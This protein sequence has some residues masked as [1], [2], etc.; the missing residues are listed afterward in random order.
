MVSRTPLSEDENG[1]LKLNLVY[2]SNEFPS[3]DLSSLFTRLRESSKRHDHPVLSRF[4]DAA[5]QTL[6]QEIGR[7]HTEL[8]HL[9]PA[10]ESVTTLA[11]ELELRKG[12]LCGSID[13]VL[14][15]VLQLATYIGYCEN[16]P[17]PHT[18]GS[19]T[20]LLA[21]LGIGLLVSTAVSVSTSLDDL[22]T[23]GVEVL[24]IAFRLGLHVR[25]VSL[26]LEAP[27]GESSDSWAWCIYGLTANDA[28]EELDRIQERDA[29]PAA[30]RVF[31]SALNDTSVTVSGPPSRLKALFRTSGFFRDRKF[32]QLPV[33]GGLCHAPHIY[34]HDDVDIVVQALSLPSRFQPIVPVMSTNTGQ[35]FAAS[36]ASNLIHQV[37]FEIMTKQI[38]WD[39]VV[40]GVTERVGKAEIRHASMKA[41][42]VSLPIQQLSDALTAAIP[43]VTTNIDDL[44]SWT[45][46]S[47][48][49]QP[50][51]PR[52]S[53]QSKIAI[54]GMSCRMPGG[55]TDTQKFWELLEGGIDVHR[56]IPADRFDVESH[57]DV[58]GKKMNTSH[59]AYGCFI[60]EPGL[61]DAPFFNMSPREAEQTDPMQRLALVTAY[62]ALERSGYLANRT[63]A[64]NLARIGTWYGQASDDY[65]EVNTAQE[66]STYFI[67]GGCRAFG[68]GR[69]NYFF[70]FSGPSFNCDT[71]CS[72]SLATIQAACT[73][74]WAGDVDTVVAG[75]LNVLTNSDAFAGLC[76]G[77]FLTKTPNACKTWDCQADGYCRADGIGSIVLKRLD[78]AEADNDN[79]LGVITAAATNH[80]ANAVS[81]THPHAGHQADLYRQVM[82]R[83]CVNPLDVS[84][85]E[86]HGTGTQAGDAEEMQSITEVFAPIKGKRR[87]AKQAL[88]IGAVKANVG[89]GE[90][91]AGVTAL[92]KVLLMLQKSTIPPHIGIK[93]DINPGFPQDMEKRNLHI[94]FKPTDW[95]RTPD[96]KRIAVINNF[97]AA[98]GNTTVAL[99][100]P[101]LR[102]KIGTDPRPSHVFTV[103]AKSKRSLKG[104]VERLLNFLDGHPDVCLADLAYSL[105]ARRYHHNHRLAIH[106]AEVGSLKQQLISHLQETETQKHVSGPDAPPVAFVFTGQGAAE[107]SMNLQLYHHSPFFHAQITHLNL[108]AQGHRFPSFI[109][110]IDGSFPRDH[111]FSPVITQVAH[112]CVQIALAK[113]WETLGVKPELVMGHSLGEY[114]AFCVAGILSASDAIFLVGSR[115]RMLESLCTAGSHCMLAIKASLSAIED[116]VNGLSYDLACVNAP[117]ETVL[118]GTTAQMDEISSLLRDLGFRCFILDVPFAFHSAQMDPILNELEELLRKAV[119]FRAPTLPIVSA[120]LSKV[121]FDE[122]SVNAEY[123]RRATRETVNFLAAIQNAKTTSS[124]DKD[125]VWVEIG[126]HPVC[127]AFIKAIMEPAPVTVGSFCRGED[128]WTTLSQALGQLH[129]A[130]LQIRWGEFHQPFEGSLRLLD[131]PTYCW[132]EKRH[133]IQ[134]KG[135]WALTKGNT[136]YDSRG[137]SSGTST[138]VSSLRTATVQN[139]LE[140]TFTG[141]H[142]KVVMQ[143]DLMQSSFLAAAHGH[144]MNG[145]GVV[146][147]SIHADIAYTLSEYLYRQLV[148]KVETIHVDITHLEVT[149][150]LVAQKN[151]K[152]PQMIR[153]T[154]STVD[155]S[156]VGADLIWQNVSNDGGVSEPFA[157]C[158]ILYGNASHWLSSWASLT[159]L[160]Q[161]R[162]DALGKLAEEG[163]ASRFSHNMAYTLFAHNLVDYADNY[164]GM[165]IVVLNGFEAY[166]D[167]TLK[168]VHGHGDYTVPPYFID[169]VA[170][171]AG[172]IMNVSDASNSAETFC[173]TPGWK[174]MRFA[175]PL[176][177][178]QS[179][180]SYVKMIP[181]TEDPSVHFGD[182]YVLQK[183]EII[184]MVG[185][186][187]FRR[188]PRILL[189][190]FFS[191]PDSAVAKSHAAGNAPNP[192]KVIH[193][194]PSPPKPA[195][196]AQLPQPTEV[197]PTSVEAKVLPEKSSA[198]P[199]PATDDQDSTAHKALVLIAKEAG[200]N[201]AELTDDAEFA[202]LGVDSL[203]SLV[204][205]EKFREELGVNVAGSLFL[206]YP[207][208]GVLKAWLLEYY[209]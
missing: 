195:Q 119:L 133:W 192:P 64:T 150:G 170:H 62:E 209:S 178:G 96:R 179:Y 55:A 51:Q 26:N 169:S 152:T 206:E 180:R 71:A 161:G 72:S 191:A 86:F 165:Q 185:G 49:Q 15:C 196:S 78:D 106:A 121:V 113:Y 2:F 73:A 100:E 117:K 22:V 108:L 128:N 186:I 146:T 84:Y 177:G 130:G 123:V 184:G 3:D 66:I 202:N 127:T 63:R 147:S 44:L 59:T 183:S 198:V 36:S 20:S 153:V 94:P 95:T 93:N 24:R 98:G 193:P 175:R 82:S 143:S 91:A 137:T 101:P 114:A 87:T 39:G 172:F 18:S 125:T 25:D 33:Y 7:L 17:E 171:L 126:P 135:D 118:S 89:H 77:H 74:L 16:S 34:N 142:G 60:N 144:R 21:G 31:V 140:E 112:T 194:E 138:P 156:T 57:H 40:R 30:S 115:A 203:M 181:T 187:Q 168:E 80:S 132:N 122:N 79:I 151:T 23:S 116:A 136:F 81:I 56:K 163:V 13:G 37:V 160:I 69:I 88:H 6:R 27:D 107:K 43:N 53:M 14:L 124:I 109:P 190:R 46:M 8:S 208:I 201:L 129:C 11:G 35:P 45:A 38:I 97:S 205:A 159:H 50:H 32:T 157:T 4:L 58:T 204:I 131:L 200:F 105:T 154:A 10:F 41:F 19:G 1:G 85:V 155:V 188:Y 189:N 148:P 47:D 9:V 54:V 92:I 182:V 65:R 76:N 61:F 145:C 166:A 104:N 110:A 176:V 42:R 28:Q 134:Y 174:S 29:I 52:G 139:I 75:G 67:P 103:S 199:T 102:E 90:A 111:V 120:L 197:V 158:R 162:I 141:T 207:T 70:K 5:T 99:E 164:R 12:P 173:V 48:H 167:V 149:K 68:P 83:A